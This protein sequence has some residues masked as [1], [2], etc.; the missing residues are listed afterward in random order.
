MKSAFFAATTIIGV[1]VFG[2]AVR[3]AEPPYL[4]DRTD[5]AAIIRSLYNAISRH[6]YARAWDYFGDT[7]PAKDFD[8]FAK[9]YEG[10][11]TV[12][13]LTGNAGSEGAAG[14]IYYTIPVAIR[15]VD[16]AGNGKV[17]AGCYTLRQVNAEVQAPPFSPIRIEKGALKLSDKEFGE[18]L[19]ESCGDSPPIPKKDAELDQ[20]KRAFLASYGEACDPE[21]PAGRQIGDPTVYDIRYKSADDQPEK[22]ARL[23]QFFC[24]M[25][26]YNENSI[27]YFSDAEQS[28][29]QL[30]FAVPDLDIRYEN[31]NTEGKVEHVGIVGFRTVDRLI[32]A[33]YDENNHTIVSHDK[34]RGVGDA[35]S[36]G[37]YL[38]RNG[39]FALVQYDVDASYDGE[40]NL[41][42]VIDYN[43]AP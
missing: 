24:S 41:E 39:V 27:F 18:A 28:V 7:K 2:Q 22:T 31:G 5:A 21:G 42:T 15:A 25:A 6:E 19:P 36:D 38:F 20:A 12:E 34:W 13:V 17:F 16:K 14:S 32:N 40:V 4:D 26:A 8:S 33:S 11:E 43:T 35:S 3:A 29:N 9:G 1:A 30:Q 37:T 23:F 10:T